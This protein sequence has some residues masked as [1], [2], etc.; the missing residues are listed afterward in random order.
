MLADCRFLLNNICP[1]PMD[2]LAVLLVEATE[3]VDQRRAQRAK[4]Q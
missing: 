3:A 1:C 2:Y 4:G